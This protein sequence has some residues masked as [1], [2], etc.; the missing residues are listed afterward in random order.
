MIYITS[1]G[2]STEY[3][4]S[5]DRKGHVVV[6]I[7]GCSGGKV[8]SA[9]VAEVTCINVCRTRYHIDIVS[10]TIESVDNDGELVA[11]GKERTRSQHQPHT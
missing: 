3:F 6:Y 10:I 4:D 11:W 5:V 1:N 8:D 7:D 2:R 9:C